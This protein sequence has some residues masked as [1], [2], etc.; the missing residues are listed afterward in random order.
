MDINVK[1]AINKIDYNLKQLLNDVVINENTQGYYFDLSASDIIDDKEI[2]IKAKINKDSLIT[3]L[4]KWEYMSNS[5]DNTSNVVERF[6][7]IDTI[8]S[9]IN[10][11]IKRKKFSKEYLDSLVIKEQYVNESS[12][13][14]LDL[15][16]ED[17]IKNV[18]KPKYSII[19]VEKVLS[20][21][22]N[23]NIFIKTPYK[24]YF[25]LDKYITDHTEKFLLEQKVMDIEYVDYIIFKDNIL[26]ISITE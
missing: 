17:K 21:K 11:V 26:E 12:D 5:N 24:L 25:K 18:I 1:L 9:D 15:T 7:T 16:I 22:E 14:T 3:N 19:E 10:D 23:T 20:L 2:T 4:I 6:S 8:H 13:E